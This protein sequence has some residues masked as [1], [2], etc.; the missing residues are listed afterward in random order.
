MMH[1]LWPIWKHRTKFSS[2]AADF[3]KKAQCTV[4]WEQYKRFRGE[5]S[6]FVTVQIISEEVREYVVVVHYPANISLFGGVQTI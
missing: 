2:G 1:I 6:L 3:E 4:I 5:K